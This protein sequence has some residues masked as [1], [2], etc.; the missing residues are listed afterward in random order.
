M[1]TIKWVY[2]KTELRTIERHIVL[3]KKEWAAMKK[4]RKL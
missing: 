1:K 4:F 2:L 3:S